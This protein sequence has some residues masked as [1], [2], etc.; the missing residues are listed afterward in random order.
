MQKK[1]QKFIFLIIINK[2]WE[3]V[4][5]KYLTFHLSKKITI[6]KDL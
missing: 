3:F 5:K 1:L 2:N 6:N 4:L